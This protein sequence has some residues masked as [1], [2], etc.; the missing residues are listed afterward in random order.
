MFTPCGELFLKYFRLTIAFHTQKSLLARSSFCFKYFG[1]FLWISVQCV[2]AKRYHEIV[3]W[4]E[5]VLI[6][7]F[8][9]MKW[10]TKIHNF[11]QTSNYYFYSYFY[12]HMRNTIYIIFNGNA[13]F[14]STASKRV[15]FYD[16][17]IGKVIVCWHLY[18]RIICF[19]RNVN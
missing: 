7:G 14:F 9:R 10:S 18:L 19:S 13:N 4:G 8:Q 1:Y 6:L 11:R 17:E 16:Y 15:F 2:H 12:M 3:Q 5:L